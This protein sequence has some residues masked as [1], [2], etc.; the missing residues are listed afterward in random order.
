MIKDYLNKEAYISQLQNVQYLYIRYGAS[1][2][3]NDTWK[4]D[5]IY[6]EM[7]YVAKQNDIYSPEFYWSYQDPFD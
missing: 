7:M 5:E 6:C 1:G 2:N 3:F 4:N